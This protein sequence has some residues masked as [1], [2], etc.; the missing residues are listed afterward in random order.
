MIN[1]TRLNELKEEVGEDDFAEVFEIFREEVEEVLDTLQATPPSQLADRLHFLKGS[2][3]NI[4]FDELGTLCQIEEMRL[5]NDPASSID[6][7]RIRARYQASKA[8]L[9]LDSR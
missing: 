5:K 8:A 3:L 9:G 4:G 2:A 7:P 1:Q 6:I